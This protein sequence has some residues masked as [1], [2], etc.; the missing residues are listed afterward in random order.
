MCFAGLS[1]FLQPNTEWT[2]SVLALYVVYV[3]KTEITYSF[4]YLKKGTVYVTMCI[5]K[6]GLF[7]L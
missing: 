1:L 5:G 2:C 7:F 4:I 6:D 3:L